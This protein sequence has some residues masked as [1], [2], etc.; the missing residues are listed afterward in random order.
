[1]STII[2]MDGSQYPGSPAHHGSPEK[3]GGKKS[4][5]LIF[6]SMDQFL[7]G[8]SVAAAHVGIRMGM[9]FF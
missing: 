9:I 2:M 7:H 1:M 8:S 3:S 6:D 5:G 4:G